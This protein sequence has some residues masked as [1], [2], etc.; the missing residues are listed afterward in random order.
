MEIGYIISKSSDERNKGGTYNK[1]VE[2]KV[3][4]WEAIDQANIYQT[5]HHRL[6]NINIRYNNM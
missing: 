6:G 1:N 4:G 2:N 5:T 3:K